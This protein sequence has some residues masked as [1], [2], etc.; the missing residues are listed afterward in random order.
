MYIKKRVKLI[1]GLAACFIVD[2]VDIVAKLDL[3]PLGDENFM[4]FFW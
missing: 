4:R 1:T 2:I 3:T